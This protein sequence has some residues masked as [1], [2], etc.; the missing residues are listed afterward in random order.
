MKQIGL[1]LVGWGM[2]SGRGEDFYG[3][4]NLQHMTYVHIKYFTYNFRQLTK[5]SEPKI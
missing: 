5:H 3:N 4:S 2:L 1:I